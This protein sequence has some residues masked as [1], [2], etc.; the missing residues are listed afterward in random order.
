MKGRPN[1]PPISEV[2]WL[3]VLETRRDEFGVTG[4]AI[5]YYL[6]PAGHA[7]RPKLMNV[8]AQSL[9]WFH[10]ACREEVDMLAIVKFAASLDALASGGEINGISKLINARLGVSLDQKLF[11]N[12]QT[13]RE[14]LKDI[15]SNGRSRTIHGTNDKFGYDWQSTRHNA[16]ILS[17]L[18][19]IL[20]LDHASR[21]QSDDP[22]SLSTPQS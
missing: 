4:E 21:F 18:C 12:G 6:D 17:R 2:D 11:N 13:V 19:L 5:A 7:A 3:R 15:Y 10:E 1:G 9:L 14:A 22:T 16:E 20:C 8:F